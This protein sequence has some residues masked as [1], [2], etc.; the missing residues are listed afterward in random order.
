MEINDR[1]AELDRLKE[2][3][4]HKRRIADEAEAAHRQYEANLF[5]DLRELG[6]RT[7]RTDH[8][9]FQRKST[10]YATVTD[11]DELLE[12]AKERGLDE[13]LFSDK[14]NKQALNQIVR[15]AIDSGQELP[16]G[17]NWYPREYISITK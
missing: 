11:K 5:A 7:I 10:V 6:L 13:E 15:D 12:W 16:P 4:D 3:R 2:D 1:L 14:P 9:Q 8:A 17:V